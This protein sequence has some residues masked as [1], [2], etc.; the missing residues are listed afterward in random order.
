MNTIDDLEAD[1]ELL[2]LLES[3]LVKV[4]SV[5]N[6]FFVNECYRESMVVNSIETIQQGSKSLEFLTNENRNKAII[7][8]LLSLTGQNIITKLSDLEELTDK[9][10]NKLCLSYECLMGLSNSRVHTA[11][12]VLKNVKLLKAAHSRNLIELVGYP[13]GGSYTMLQKL[14]IS[15]LPILDPPKTGDFVSADDR[16]VNAECP[17]FK[18]KKNDLFPSEKN[19]N[20]IIN[21]PHQLD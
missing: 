16:C 18:K 14:V 17:E 2:D 13:T 5:F 20:D 12:S 3:L 21:Y 6:R 1:T 9:K 8:T 15:P 10:L 19:Y 4:S 7:N 11:P